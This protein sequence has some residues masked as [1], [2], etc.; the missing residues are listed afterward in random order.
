M[1]KRYVLTSISLILFVAVIVLSVQQ[2]QLKQVPKVYNFT[3]ET[4]DFR[5]QGL[6]FVV[7]QGSNSVYVTGH[8]LEVTGADQQFAG[9]VYGISIEDQ[10]ILSVNQAGDPF[11]L[12]DTYEGKRHYD[13]RYLMEN[14]KVKAQDNVYI[15]IKYTVNGTAKHLTGNVKLHSLMKPFSSSDQ[16]HIIQL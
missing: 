5:L 2:F 8:D 15:E 10:M 4:D 9:I 13:T 7:N 12:P 16:Q 14:V 1:R 3:V 11:T 6:E